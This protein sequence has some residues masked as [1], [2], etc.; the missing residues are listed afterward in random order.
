MWVLERG[1][2]SRLVRRVSPLGGVLESGVLGFAGIVCVRIE[3]GLG[4]LT[5]DSV[6]FG[7]WEVERLHFLSCAF[8]ICVLRKGRR[9][10]AG[11]RM[12]V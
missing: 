10:E 12:F 1:C 8:F 9:G 11:T 5:V 4:C 7:E 6:E 2:R 3:D